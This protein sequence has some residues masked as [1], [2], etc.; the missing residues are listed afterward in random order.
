MIIL[1]ILESPVIM[2][3][4]HLLMLVSKWLHLNQ[5]K[6][7]LS[8]RPHLMWVVRLE[9]RLWRKE[10]RRVARLMLRSSWLKLAERVGRWLKMLNAPPEL[11]VRVM[12]K[13]GLPPLAEVQHHLPEVAAE[14]L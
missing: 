9:K 4:L 11:L 12:L 8:P 10:Q 3:S 5:V 14:L 13:L 7:N 2:L 6:E 1:A